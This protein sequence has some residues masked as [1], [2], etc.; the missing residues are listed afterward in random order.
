MALQPRHFIIG[1]LG[2]GV[3]GALGWLAFRTEPVPVDLAEIAR[4]P[5]LVTV[6]AE[7]E[8]RVKDVFEVAAPIFGTARRAPVEAGDPV[9]AGE[10]V[11]AVVE[12]AA[13]ALL[14]ARSRE[15]A[16]AAVNEA[17]AALTLA[18]A[19]LRQA[20][21]EL[22]YARTQHER[23]RTLADRGVTAQTVL[24][25]ASQLL[26]IRLAAREAARSNVE[27]A[28]SALA[29]ARA[30]LN[31]PA[32]V[33]AARDSCCVT[34]R[35]PISGTVL[36]VDIVS[37][38]PVAAGT[39]LLSLGRTDDLEIVADLLSSDAVGLTPG[40]R[41]IVDRWGGT[42][43]LEARL[44]S[45]DPSA[46]TKVSALGIE[47]QRVDAVFDFV[48]PPEARAG[49]GDRY[50]VYLRIVKWEGADVIQVPLPALF[51]HEGGWA[52]FRAAGGAAAL[53]PVTLGHRND[54]AAEVKEG[55]SPADLVI[56]HP[57]DAIVDGTPVAER[58]A[59]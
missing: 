3:A 28:T 21:E 7:G 57:A 6:N 4:G 35:A 49:L 9:V 36:S 26:A 23:A 13:P 29:R 5:M 8:T 10:T 25:D 16:E 41:A 39:R 20:E 46:H 54:T 17:R 58:T 2:A 31:P 50:A 55:V 53:T 40:T 43:P 52:V 14:D 24:E 48:S 47:E 19:Q 12:P 32:T 37:E 56:L 44:R 59:D 27:M 18:E 33:G 51:R 11:V 38:T 42:P 45:L 1:L 15:Q 22:H 34:I 30:V